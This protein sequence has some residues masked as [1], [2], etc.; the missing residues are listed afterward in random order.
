V[1]TFP[2]GFLWGAA[3]SSHQ[4][5][6]GNSGNDWWEWE[7]R[8]HAKEPSGAAC[9]QWNR[10]R[11]DFEIAKS[12]HH[13]A[14]RLSLEWSRIEP[15]EGRFD[16]DALHHYAEVLRAL[17]SLGL[18]P[19]VTLY[20]FTLPLWLSRQGGWLCERSPMLF[21][22]YARKVS[23]MI[24]EGVHYWL[25]INEPEVYVYKGY[26][27]GL[28]PPG[29]KS[30]QKLWVALG[31][32]LRAHVEGYDAIKAGA[33]NFKRPIPMVSLAK[34]CAFFSACQTNSLKDRFSVWLRDLAFNRLV[35]DTLIRGHFF[36]PAMFKIRLRKARTLDFIGINYYSRDFIHFKG[37]KGPE[38]FGEVCPPGHHSEAGSRNDLSWEIYPK[39]LYCLVKDFSRHGLPIIITENG[40]C[41]GDDALRAVFIED[42]LRELARAMKEGARVIG[43]L[44]WSLLDNF[45]W[46]EGFGPRFGLV[47]VD[48]SSQRRKIRDSARRYAEICRTGAIS[49]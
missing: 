46:A 22:R 45:E 7:R 5:E 16:E 27:E 3:T 30:F 47:E 15:E 43:Y 31:N 18:E 2:R 17:R 14:H 24:G 19:V 25:T 9:D 11:E 26:L 36:L 37:L 42:H 35:V 6:G 10:F 41:T 29:E 13:N 8:G 49:G 34:A 23:E 28:W 40:V 20:H 44:Y 33:R 12:L 48:Y 1:Q 39:G 32:L 21:G 38:I 4:V